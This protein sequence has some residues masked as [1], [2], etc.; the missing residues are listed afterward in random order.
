MKEETKNTKVLVAGATGYLGKYLVKELKR[1]GFWVRILIRKKNQKLLFDDI[2]I[3][4]YFIGQITDATSIN[5]ITK[6]INWVFSSIGI[7]RQKDKMTYME[8]DYQGNLNLLNDA[9]K[10]KVKKFQYIS[11]I[12]GNELRQ[13]KI[14]EAK[15]KFVEKLK[16]SGIDY[17]IIRP[18]AFFSDMRDFLDMAKSGKVFLFGDGTPKLNPI[19]G[20]DLATVCIDT[21]EKNEKEITAGGNNV[22]T[23]NEIAIQ[24]LK[25]W[26]KPT[27]I[28]HLPLWVKKLT[29]GVMRTFT[30]SKIYGPIEFFLTAM[31]MDNVGDQY[32]VEKLEDFFL[33]EA[34]KSKEITK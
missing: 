3:D 23:Q 15:E 22:F 29:V 16:E 30:S 7:T 6:D 2:T 18:T 9:L 20:K 34:K 1:R 14:F 27:K 4:D 5:D 17:R 21:M 19:H 11:A 13:L 8:V 28:V 10:N 32:G 25:V 33:E 12:N 31:S 24:A 26:Q